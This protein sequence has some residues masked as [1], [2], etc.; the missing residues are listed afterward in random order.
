M[1]G[2]RMTTGIPPGFTGLTLDRADH[3]RLEADRIA[4]L[5]A[6]PEAKLMA[7]DGMD[8][9]LSEDGRLA[10][11]PAADIGDP[12]G[13]I[14]IGLQEAVPLFAPAAPADSGETRPNTFFLLASMDAEDVALWGIAR[15]LIA[16]HSRHGFCSNCGHPTLAFR[17]GWGR[18]CD[19]CASEHFPRIDP[20]VIMLAEHHGKVLVGRQGRFP[21][22]SFS[23]LAGYVE[24][25]ESI[26]EAVA[27]ELKEEAG[28]S[29]SNVRYLVSQH[30]PFSGALMI[31]CLAE[32][33][34]DELT[35]DPTELEGAMW[36]DR[37]GVAAALAYE[38]AAPFVPPPHY[39]IAHSL[40]RLWLQSGPPS[41]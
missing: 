35:L 34:S 16:W 24:P 7:F 3:L 39:A 33:D 11:R 10:W 32:A 9:V 14:F 12:A 13:L 4:A 8:P 1:A 36:V 23:A 25:G 31:A 21:P 17:A 28:I 18:R 27:R 41:A 37:P 29:V 20:V 2:R 19:N 38:E 26:E 30:W 5:A 22:R 40:L 15:S 6:S